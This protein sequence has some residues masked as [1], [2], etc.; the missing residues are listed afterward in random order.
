[1]PATDIV[2]PKRSVTSAAPIFRVDLLGFARD[3]PRRVVFVTTFKLRVH[4]GRIDTSTFSKE[5]FQVNFWNC[6]PSA[7]E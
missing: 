1:M 5:G 2:I 6:W 3:E 4:N 7:L